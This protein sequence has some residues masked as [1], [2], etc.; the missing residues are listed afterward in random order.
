MTTL[1]N[2][3]F[4]QPSNMTILV[5]LTKFYLIV[6][7]PLRIYKRYPLL[8]TLQCKIAEKRKIYDTRGQGTLDEDFEF[9]PFAGFEVSVEPTI[10]HTLY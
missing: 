10:F 9:N 3:P 4:R 8:T 1:P 7:Y 5:R 6:K 2:K